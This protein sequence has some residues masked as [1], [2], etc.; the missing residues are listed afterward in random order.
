VVVNDLKVE[1]AIA[2]CE[3]QGTLPYSTLYYRVK[4]ARKNGTYNSILKAK[5]EQALRNNTKVGI[6]I[7]IEHDE[8]LSQSSRNISPVTMKTLSSSSNAASS[9]STSSTTTTA[10]TSTSTSSEA[11]QSRKSSRQASVERLE[12]KRLKVDYN[13]RYKAAA[14]KEA[15]SLVASCTIEPVLCICERLNLKYNL[16]GKKRLARSTVYD[17]ARGCVVGGVSPKTKGPK[18]KIPEDFVSMVA[19]HAEVC[20]VGDGELKGRD[21]KRLIGAS[22]VG[23]QHEA[24][25]KVES[26][27]RKVRKDFP[28]WS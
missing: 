20:Q 25:F 3:M 13:G 10:A 9:S 6:V 7:N 14:F 19:T 22:I 12:A 11:I 18:P 24:A 15:T 21:L 28:E 2:A 5:A 4:L 27:W 17:A 23:T 8:D 16:D 1:Q 26:V